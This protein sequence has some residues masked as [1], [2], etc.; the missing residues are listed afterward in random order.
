MRRIA[1]KRCT[2]SASPIQDAAPTTSIVPTD[3]ARFRDEL[4][5][6]D[7]L[8]GHPHVAAEYGELKGR[9][10]QIFE[11]DRE[12]YTNAKADFIRAILRC[13]RATPTSAQDIYG[14]S[15]IDRS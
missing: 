6:R 13:A 2:G 1:S 4:L 10:A 5:F 7:Y 3:S 15:W 14:E 11:R 9:L 8:R 12:A